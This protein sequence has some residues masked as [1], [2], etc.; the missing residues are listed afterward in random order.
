MTQLTPVQKSIAG[1]EWQSLTAEAIAA[2]EPMEAGA[3]ANQLQGGIS[4][5]GILRISPK[6]H[7]P[8][9]QAV[10]SVLHALKAR[11]Q[12][13]APAVQPEVVEAAPV[14]KPQVKKARPKRRT[15]GSKRS[16]K[17]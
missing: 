12:S 15:K 16:A 13:N 6:N 10:L 9:A 14:E 11:S 4:A 1:I 8:E 17:K 5:S 3:T 2:M 7:P